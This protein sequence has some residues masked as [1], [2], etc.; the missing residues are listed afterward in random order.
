MLNLGI[1]NPYIFPGRP[2]KLNR[3][4]PLYGVGHMQNASVAQGAG[5]IDLVTGVY[6]AGT[7]TLMGNDENGPY[8]WSNDG[9]GTAACTWSSSGATVHYVT[10]GCIFKL[11][12]GSGRGYPWNYAGNSGVFLNGLVINFNITGGTI[13]TGITGIAGHTYFAFCN[14][15]TGGANLTRTNVLID[16]TTGQVSQT[17]TPS[18]GNV[19]VNPITGIGLAGAF[20]SNTRLYAGFMMSTALVPPIVQPSP[21]FYSADQINAGIADPWGLWYG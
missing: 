14:N 8:V 17:R 11:T 16:L 5:M 12:T 13:G 6:A 3:A 18:T 20:N 10:W 7:T 21:T 1:R 19:V 4:H 15:A 2:P 9:A